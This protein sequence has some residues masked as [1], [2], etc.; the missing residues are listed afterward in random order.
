MMTLI[1]EKII[2]PQVSLLIFYGADS[3]AKASKKD[4]R[5]RERLT[6]DQLAEEVGFANYEQ[7]KR[8]AVVTMMVT[9]VT[10]Q[11]KERA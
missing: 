8:N 3:E 11:I 10:A 6:C 4:I 1:L 7:V 9:R 5:N 2:F